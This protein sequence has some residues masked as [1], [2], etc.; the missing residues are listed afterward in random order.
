[1]EFT[2][3]H[4]DNIDIFEIGKYRRPNF[5]TNFGFLGFECIFRCN[6]CTKCSKV[7]LLAA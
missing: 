1:M 6:T 5:L 3:N 7:I 4:T 2:G